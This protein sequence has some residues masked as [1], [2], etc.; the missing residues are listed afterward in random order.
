M[1]QKNPIMGKTSITASQL[2]DFVKKRNP[3]F[4]NKI[5]EAFINIAPIY[6]I[7]GDVAF[8]Q[9]IH[10]TDWFRFT[11]DVNPTQNNFAGIGAVGGGARGNA[12]S[13]VEEGVRAQIQHLFAYAT[14]VNLPQG[15]SLVDP[16][17][18][19]VKR[20]SA[21]YWEDLAGKWAYPGYNTRKFKSL[22]QAFA[23]GESYGQLIINIHERLIAEEGGNVVPNNQGYPE[24][25]EQWKIN[26]VEW[27]YENGF[28]TS[29]EW[30]QK[31]EEPLPLWA[32]ATVYNR[33][34]REL[35]GGGSS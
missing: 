26:A 21:P 32:Q 6:G 10:E 25:T 29:D 7:R 27:L 22:Q 18:N 23:A 33:L 15:E 12:F 28:L 2:I 20:G 35:K 11:G 5:A 31:I 9:A 8:C 19:L 14:T 3:N 17:F 24:G 16:R 1:I 30:K 13:T 4:N 34:I